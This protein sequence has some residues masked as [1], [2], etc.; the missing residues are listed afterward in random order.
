MIFQDMLTR[1]FKVLY[2]RT[3]LPAFE[4][5]KLPVQRSWPYSQLT[6][7]KAYWKRQLTSSYLISLSV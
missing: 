5:E 2:S 3:H 7:G 6:P 1:R 4:A